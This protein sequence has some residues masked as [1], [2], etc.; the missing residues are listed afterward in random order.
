[1]KANKSFMVSHSVFSL[2]THFSLNADI[3]SN[4]GAVKRKARI[5]KY[6]IETVLLWWWNKAQC[7]I[8][9]NLLNE[10]KKSVLF[11]WYQ[12]HTIIPLHLQPYYWNRKIW[13]YNIW[14]IHRASVGE[15]NLTR[16]CILPTWNN[17]LSRGVLVVKCQNSWEKERKREKKRER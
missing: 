12:Y 2:I 15:R 13:N 3:K 11:I 8:N 10:S 6:Q 9:I 16:Y 7:C 1:M 4:W 14:I 5:V 17:K